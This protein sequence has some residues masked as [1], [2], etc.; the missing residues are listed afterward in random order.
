M[1]EIWERFHKK[2]WPPK[3]DQLLILVLVGLLLAV[4]AIPSEQKEKEE[5]K[6]KLVKETAAEEEKLVEAID[7]ESQME[8]RL[9]EILSQVEGVGKVRVMLTFEGSGQ[10]I[11]EKDRS[12]SEDSSQEETVFEELGSNER[13]PYITSETNPQVEGILV[14]AQGGGNSRVKQEILEAAQALFGIEP[15]KIKIMKMEGT[16]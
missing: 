14:I 10:K 4:I 9:E 6:G 7:Y 11:V 15:H 8:Q 12:Y 3:K 2:Y 5:E 16:R 13:S 1:K